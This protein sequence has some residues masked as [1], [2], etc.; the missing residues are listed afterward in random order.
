M[1]KPVGF[2][3]LT[4]GGLNATGLAKPW[5]GR[6]TFQ[7]VGRTTAGAGTATVLIRGSVDGTN[8]DLIG[9]MTLAFTTAEGSDSIAID[10][11][12]PHIQTEVTA[13]AGTNS[14]VDV[15]LGG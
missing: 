3:F 4:A 13:I 6:A 12:W 10:A 2:K 14:T 8:Y 15:W 9:T 1:G 7:A 5:T 11:A